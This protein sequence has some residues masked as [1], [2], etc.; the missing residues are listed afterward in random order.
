MIKWSADSRKKI[1]IL[2]RGGPPGYPICHQN[3]LIKYIQRLKKSLSSV[4]HVQCSSFENDKSAT[5]TAG[6][7]INFGFDSRCWR[8]N[9]TKAIAVD[10]YWVDNSFKK[11]WKSIWNIE[12]YPEKNKLATSVIVLC[13]YYYVVCFNVKFWAELKTYLVV[14]TYH[15]SLQWWFQ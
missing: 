5:P 12:S 3:P 7:H 13:T 4:Y 2:F 8:A 14:Y 1:E 6:R 15:P 9:Q 10:I 11:D